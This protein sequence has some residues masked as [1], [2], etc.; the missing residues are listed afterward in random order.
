MSIM[1]YTYKEMIIQ[2]CP[3]KAKNPLCHM[4]D[5]T[6]RILFV[7]I[8]EKTGSERVQK[9]TDG[10]QETARD[11]EHMEDRVEDVAAVPDAV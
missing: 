2:G 8:G 10:L 3:A 1:L 6:Q 5:G 7:G 9:D 11:N 4:R